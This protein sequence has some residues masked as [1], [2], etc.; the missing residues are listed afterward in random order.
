MIKPSDFLQLANT[1]A[2]TDH[3]VYL[4]ESIIAAYYAAF[5]ECHSLAETL[6]NHAG[7]GERSGSH[8]EVIRKLSQYPETNTEKLPKDAVMK[9]RSIGYRLKECRNQRAIA[10][11]D[12]NININQSVQ[13]N[14]AILI[15]KLFDTLSQLQEA[16]AASNNV[17]RKRQ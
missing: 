5:H 15:N 4:R 11:Y 2:Q 3:E 7:M 14:H 16:C 12:L 10:S 1:L 13:Q 6:T 9:I 8:E 17:Q